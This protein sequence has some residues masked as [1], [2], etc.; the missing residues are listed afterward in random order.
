MFPESLRERFALLLRQVMA[1]LDLP[2][3]RAKRERRPTRLVLTQ[4][5]LRPAA[6]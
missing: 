3:V 1:E 2:P 6:V 5:D 4:H